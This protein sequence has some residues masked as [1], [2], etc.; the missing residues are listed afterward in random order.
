[1]KDDGTVQGV[2]N[3]DNIQEA[4]ETGK[5]T[6]PDVPWRS[7]IYENNGKSCVRVE[8]GYAKRDFTLGRPSLSAVGIGD[9]ESTG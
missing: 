1:M 3:P 9:V 7:E 5:R 6:Y 8:I 4:R 2:S